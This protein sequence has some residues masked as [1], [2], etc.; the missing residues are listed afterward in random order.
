M[1]SPSPLLAALNARDSGRSPEGTAMRTA[2]S[3]S[4]F[5]WGPAWERP[6]AGPRVTP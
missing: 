2:L 6:G 5:A 4:R 3:R 1:V